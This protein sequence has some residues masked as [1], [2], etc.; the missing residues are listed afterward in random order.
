MIIYGV[1]FAVIP[2]AIIAAIFIPEFNPNTQD[3]NPDIEDSQST[4]KLEQV[5]KED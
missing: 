3:F 4:E 5:I 2:I 1:L